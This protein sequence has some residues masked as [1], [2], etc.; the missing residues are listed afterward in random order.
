MPYGIQQ[1]AISGQISQLEKALGTKLFHRRPFGL[2][3]AG[4]KLFTEIERFFAG[5]KELPG[6]VRGYAQQRLRLAAPARILRDYLPN[7]LAGYR[8]RFP[9]FK[10][11]LFDANQASAE[12]LLRKHEIDLGITELEGRPAAAIKSCALIRLPLALVVPRRA[13]FGSISDILD[14]PVPSQNLIALPPEEV[15]TKQFQAALK[16][17]G[18]AWTPA[19][20]LSSLEL[21]DTYTALGFGVGLSIALPG[22]KIERTLRLMPL[23]NFPP[24]TVAAFWIGD[25]SGIAASFLGDVKKLAAR[26]G[27]SR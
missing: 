24:V 6:H 16:K 14:R 26:L 21:I 3:V 10:L 5:L 22:R 2:T 9:D 27:R 7:I 19:I 18:L 15:I 11:T 25:L 1:P 13:H 20:E 12:E 23:K 4:R 17:L 8:R